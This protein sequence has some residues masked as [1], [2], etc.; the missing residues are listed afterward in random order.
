MGPRFQK[1]ATRIHPK[2]QH[3]IKSKK[4]E[5]ITSI[6]A[7]KINKYNKHIFQLGIHVTKTTIIRYCR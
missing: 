6:L 4:Q 7:K 5:Q 2:Q 3:F 1:N